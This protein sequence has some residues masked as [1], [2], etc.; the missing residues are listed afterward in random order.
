MSGIL[1]TGCEED[2]MNVDDTAQ[3]TDD[4]AVA[5]VESAMASTTEGISSE[6]DD[7]ITLADEYTEKSNNDPCGITFDSTFARKWNE[8]GY[9][10]SFST[11][12]TWTVNCQNG[13]VPSS[14]SFLRTA[15]GTYE[16][17]NL[18]SS[19][20]A[21]GEWTVSNLLS[22]SSWILN[23]SHTRSGE[24]DSQVGDMN[25]F[26]SEVSMDFSSIAV[27][28]SQAEIVGGTGTIDVI[29]T[30]SNGTNKS[31]EGTITF[32]GNGKA[33]IVLN[34]ATYTIDLG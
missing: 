12:W 9:S 24:H 1:F 27:S 6:V 4:Q 10:A 25:T 26:K 19:D 13:R 28:K 33:T 17:P 30:G 31:W 18:E 22:G 15:N 7:A 34:G 29:L 16:G 20:Q 3:L 23:G 11:A 21:S 5:V 32:Q 2:N 8:Q 14:L